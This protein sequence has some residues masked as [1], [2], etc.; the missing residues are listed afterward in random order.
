MDNKLEVNNNRLLAVDNI[1]LKFAQIY[2]NILV[3][4]S[5]EY[6]RMLK[7]STFNH[8]SLTNKAEM[9][10]YLHEDFDLLQRAK[11]VTDQ[12]FEMSDILSIFRNIKEFMDFLPLANKCYCFPIKEGSVTYTKSNYSDFLNISPEGLYTDINIEFKKINV[13]NPH[14]I[15]IDTSSSALENYI[16][17]GVYVPSTNNTV[18]TIIVSVCRQY[19]EDSTFQWIE[20][21]ESSTNFIF[22]NTETTIEFHNIVKMILDI[23]SECYIDIIDNYITKISGVEFADYITLDQ[24]KTGK[25][26][27]PRK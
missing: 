13:P 4:V 17:T 1:F 27:I 12:T 20:T 19:G 10:F 26:L 15:T 8:K 21:S 25:V 3:D 5:E 7:P 23:L 6:T 22:N 2:Y 11:K 16:D 9:L 18:N 24:V 14:N